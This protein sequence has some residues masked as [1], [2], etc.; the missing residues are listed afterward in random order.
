[1]AYSDF[2]GVNFR[3]IGDVAA[4]AAAVD[5]HRALLISPIVR[6]WLIVAAFPKFH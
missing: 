2:V 4:M 3:R 5:L 1:M 6:D